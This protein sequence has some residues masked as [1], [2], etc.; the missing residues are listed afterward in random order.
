M[1]KP[2]SYI[3][4]PEGQAWAVGVTPGDAGFGGKAAVGGRKYVRGGGTRK[5]RPRRMRLPLDS[6]LVST[7]SS[8]SL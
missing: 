3:A 8:L 5:S 1:G 2:K 7:Q 6:P 4:G